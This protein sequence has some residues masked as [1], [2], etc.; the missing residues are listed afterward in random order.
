[1]ADVEM[2]G[3]SVRNAVEEVHGQLFEVIIRNILVNFLSFSTLSSLS[4]SLSNDFR[5]IAMTKS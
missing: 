3:G 4:F 2:T 1:M 5:V